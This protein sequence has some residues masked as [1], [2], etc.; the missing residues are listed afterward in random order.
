MIP[1]YNSSKHILYLIILLFFSCNDSTLNTID[2]SDYGLFEDDCGE[3]VQC[4][5]TCNCNL[6]E[7]DFNASK[8]NCGVCFGD[9]SLCEG[10]TNEIATNYDED[11]T[12]SCPDCCVYGDIFIIYSDQEQFQPIVHQ[13]SL[14]IPIYWLNSSNH[15]IIIESVDSSQPECMQNL[16]SDFTNTSCS[17]YTNSEQCEI[18]NQGCLW[19]IPLDYNANWDNFEIEVPAGTSLA[20]QTQYYFLGFDSPSGYSYYYQYGENT[21]DRYLGFINI[22][23]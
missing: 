9:D 8:D 14:G 7:C 17:S 12:I 1:L 4:D 15:N 2:C 19:N 5:E 18:N 3:C 20:S 11:A 13:T 16:E 22:N 23:E 6:E 21:D 10:C